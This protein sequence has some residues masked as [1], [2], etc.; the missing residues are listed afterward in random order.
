[1]PGRLAVDLYIHHRKDFHWT[2]HEGSY[3]A[4][5]AIFDRGWGVAGLSL[6]YERPITN[7]FGKYFGLAVLPADID[8][9]FWVDA[10]WLETGLRFDVPVGNRWILQTSGGLTFNNYN[11][12]SLDF[13]TGLALAFP[14]RRFGVPRDRSEG[15]Y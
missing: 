14:S 2:G 11:Q 5:A 9:P 6:R 1:V 10:I 13:R 7:L 4:P 15:P 12:L 8:G 3:D